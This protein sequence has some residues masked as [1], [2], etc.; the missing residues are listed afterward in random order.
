MLTRSRA[1][2]RV[3]SGRRTGVVV[4]LRVEVRVGADGKPDM[5]TL[6]VTGLG[7]SENRDVAAEWLQESRFQPALKDGQPVAGTFKTRVQLRGEVRRVG[8]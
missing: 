6:T 4:D 7:A 2:W 8:G 5:Q 3:P 1:E